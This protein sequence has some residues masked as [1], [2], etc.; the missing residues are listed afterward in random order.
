MLS[1][2]I[3]LHRFSFTPPEIFE[4]MFPGH[5]VPTH[6]EREDLL[7]F[8]AEQAKAI[9]KTQGYDTQT[10]EPLLALLMDYLLV[11]DQTDDDILSFIACAL[12][13]M[14]HNRAL[15]DQLQTE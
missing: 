13:M 5:P 11:Y 14:V 9:F 15:E 10:P 3:P 8:L 7:A 4:A 12:L 1:T 2:N 6:K